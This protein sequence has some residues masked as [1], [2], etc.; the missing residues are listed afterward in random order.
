[1]FIS[2]EFT[3][4]QA[5]FQV[6]KEINAQIDEEVKSQVAA[7]LQT[8]IPKKLQDEVASTK[9]Q[10]QKAQRDLSNS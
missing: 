9:R 6:E 10:L 2:S 1:V 8:I 7:Q 3:D 5:F 4:E